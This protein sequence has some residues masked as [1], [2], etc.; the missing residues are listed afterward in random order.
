MLRLA[1]YI[2]LF[3]LSCSGFALQKEAPPVPAKANVSKTHLIV[4]KSL[5]Q[6]PLNDP[7]AYP[8]NNQSSNDDRLFKPRQISQLAEQ[9]LGV[10]KPYR[11]QTLD[12]M[13]IY[14]Q[15]LANDPNLASALSANEAAQELIEQSKAL[16]RPAVNFN[17]GVNKSQTDITFLGDNPFT[18]LRNAGRNSFETKNYGVEARQP[19]YRKDSLLQID[20]SKTQVRLADKQ[21]HLA[22]QNLMLRTTLTYFDVLI[23]QENI[24]LIQAQKSAILGQLDQAKANFDVGVATITDV[25]EAQA[26]YD[27]TVSQEIAA[28]NIFEVA[29]HSVQAITGNIPQALTPVRDNIAPNQLSQAMQEWIDVASKNNLNIQINEDAYTLAEQDVERAR[30]GHLPTLDAVAS[31]TENNQSGGA[32]GFGSELKTSVIG[33][34]LQIPLY[35]GGAV[36][37]R[38]RQAVHNQDRARSD[39]EVARRQTTLDTQR[40]YLNLNTSIAQIKAFEK[41]LSSTQSQVESTKLGYE[42]GL[43]NSIE[44]LN[45]QQ[46]FFTARRDLLQARYQ[47]LINIIQLKVASGVVSEMDLVDINQQ[48]VQK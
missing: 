48:L 2:L 47:Y 5:T 1:I 38:Q 34:Q 24:A 9:T 15:A 33:L 46:Q 16:Y 22:Q 18:R 3:T 20:Q 23:A 27:L 37:S 7:Q 10:A 45:A 13:D 19:I 36:S 8:L 41:A 11:E 39:I 31:Y 21:L 42:V 12:L 26:R 14:Q 40:A 6:I 4:T 28:F 25:N 29:K 17:A 44:V 30:S 35:L 32:Q 43:R